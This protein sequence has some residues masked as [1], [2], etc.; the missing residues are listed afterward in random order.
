MSLQKLWSYVQGY[1]II[2]I[3]GS[4]V[5]RFLREA[6]KRKFV[7]W[8]VKRIQK[9]FLLASMS[10]RD[11]LAV[12]PVARTAGCRIEI[13][14]K[15]GL[16]FLGTR[17]M[18]RPILPAGVCILISLILVLSSRVWVVRI[19]G[20]KTLDVSHIEHTVRDLGLVAGVKK[21]DVDIKGLENDLLIRIPELAWV[22]VKIQG[23][24]AIVEV[25]EKVM[26]P[27][28]VA[29]GNLVAAKPGIIHKLIVLSGEAVVKDGDTV[30]E[31]DCL[32]RGVEQNGQYIK[33]K[34]IA[35]ARIWYESTKRVLLYEEIQSPTGRRKTAYY[36]RIGDNEKRIWPVIRPFKN[37]LTDSVNVKVQWSAGLL[38]VQIL[39]KSHEEVEKLTQSHTLN[40]ASRKAVAEATSTV[41][42]KLPQ[43]V[44]V[45]GQD[46][47]VVEF[48]QDGI[49]GVEARVVIEVIEEIGTYEIGGVYPN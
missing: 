41:L 39:S 23:S 44:E 13:W 32:I 19:Q 29:Q 34:G 42:E 37:F 6:A 35:Q 49:K 30:V 26:A 46:I 11:F 31:G 4:E 43:I 5:E 36:I 2:K 22:G 3:K 48:E 20:I 7:L 24:V 1:V 25:V 47:K 18:K 33:A 16:P 27:D 38:Q 15:R 9:G 45:V 10:V 21:A 40:E 12:R 8:D 28:D 14:R 17:L